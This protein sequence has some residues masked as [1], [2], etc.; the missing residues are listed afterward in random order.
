MPKNPL[1]DPNIL[2]RQREKR[3]AQKQ[4]AVAAQSNP[5][6]VTPQTPSS[7]T[8]QTAA[9]ARQKAIDARIQEL[10]RQSDQTTDTLK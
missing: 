8:P 10:L 5:A 9:Q 4:A 1:L 2:R 6:P 3:V 7:A